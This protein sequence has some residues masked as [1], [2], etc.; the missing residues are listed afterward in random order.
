M[1]HCISPFWKDSLFDITRSFFLLHVKF[2]FIY[3]SCPKG[4]STEQKSSE[5]PKDM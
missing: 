4:I 3:M 1:T 2:R 5:K